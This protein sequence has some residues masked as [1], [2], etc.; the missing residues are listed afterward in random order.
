MFSIKRV[1]SVIDEITVSECEKERKSAIVIYFVQPEDTLWTV[2]KK[3]KTTIDKIINT[4]S[5]TPSHTLTVGT[6][7]VIPTV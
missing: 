6:K 2:A 5:L 4:N 3:Y 1:I 7:L